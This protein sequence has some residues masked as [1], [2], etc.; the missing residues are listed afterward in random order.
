MRENKS[1]G[2]NKIRMI[3]KKKKEKRN[4]M[5][6]KQSNR[7]HFA[8]TTNIQALVFD[9]DLYITFLEEIKRGCLAI[10]EM[11]TNLG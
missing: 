6:S 11:L 5:P 10:S 9:Y 7:M 2:Q 4:E 8:C 1:E 3:G